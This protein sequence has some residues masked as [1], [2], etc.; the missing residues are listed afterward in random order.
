VYNLECQNVALDSEFSLDNC[1]QIR[2]IKTNIL[3]FEGE[4]FNY[5]FYYTIKYL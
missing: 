2:V 1:Y 4:I 5:I 3:G